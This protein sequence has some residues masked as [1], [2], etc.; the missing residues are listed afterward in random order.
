MKVPAKVAG[1]HDLLRHFERPA[2]NCR[3]RTLAATSAGN[4]ERARPGPSRPAGTRSGTGADPAHRRASA[5]SKS[6]SATASRTAAR[7]NI[8]SSTAC[9]RRRPTKPTKNGSSA[10]IPTIASARSSSFSMRLKAASEDYSADYRIVRPNDGEM[11]WIDVVAKI[12]RDR[13]G[14]ALRLVG[15]DIDVTDRMLAQDNLAR[16]RGALPPDRRQRAGADVGHQ[17]RPHALLRQ[18]GLCRFPRTAVRGSHRVR[19]AQAASP[20]RPAARRAGIDRRRGLAQAVRAGGA[21]PRR[22]RRMALAALGIP[23]ALGPDRQ[24]H[25][26]HRR[27]PRHHRRQA[28]RARSAPAERNPRNCGS[29]SEPRSWNP[30]KPRC[31]RS[32][33]PAISIRGCSTCTATCCMPTG[34]RWPES[35]PRPA[36]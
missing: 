31:A 8:S 29:R 2:R 27:R 22:R 16:K 19:L 6:I 30:T 28:G 36:R 32:S 25:R 18:P 1:T 9:R 35:A 26:L 11:R 12:E 17:A 23:A 33:R 3:R 14:R 7:R 13:D 20:G 34:R 10:S 4:R 15:A 21:L 24:A 5:A